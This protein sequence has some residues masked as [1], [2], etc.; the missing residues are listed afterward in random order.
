MLEKSGS[1]I[2]T[3][4]DLEKLKREEVSERVKQTWGL[5]LVQLQEVVEA[6]NYVLTTDNN[7]KKGT[8]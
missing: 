4:D 7:T 8:E 6:D 1:V 2:L 5:T 3:K